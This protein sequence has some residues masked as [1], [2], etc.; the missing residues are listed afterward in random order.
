MSL[1][2][3]FKD[4]DGV[5]LVE[6]LLA[7]GIV[8]IS[9]VWLIGAYQ[10]A[11]HLSEMSQQ[12][13]VALNDLRNMLERIKSTPFNSLNNDFPNGAPNG[14]LYGGIIGGYTLGSEQITVTHVPSVTANPRELIVQVTWTNRGRQYQRTVSTMRSSEAS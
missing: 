5:T 13:N 8:L 1:R 14:A 3:N 10:S 9:G 12:M 6:L 11:L 7:I 2:K 4:H